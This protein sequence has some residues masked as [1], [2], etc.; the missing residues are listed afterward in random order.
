MV[1]VA[2][3]KG[4]VKANMPTSKMLSTKKKVKENVKEKKVKVS[5][6]EMKKLGK[7]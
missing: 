3:Q 7:K 2:I 6:Q 1:K 5:G 4:P